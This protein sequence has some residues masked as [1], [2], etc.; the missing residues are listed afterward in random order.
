[1]RA[2]VTTPTGLA[3]GGVVTANAGGGIAID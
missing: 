2:D 3:P 1:M